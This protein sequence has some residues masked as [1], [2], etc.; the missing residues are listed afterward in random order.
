MKQIL[1]FLLCASLLFSVLAVNGGAAEENSNRDAAVAEVTEGITALSTI[2]RESRSDLQQV[3]QKINEFCYNHGYYNNDLIENLADF[4]IAIEKFNDLLN[5]REGDTNNDKDVNAKDAL[6]VLKYSVGK[7]FFDQKQ[8]F[9]AD[10]DYNNE[11]NAKDA[12][13]MLQYAVGKRTEFPSQ[14]VDHTPYEKVDYSL[15]TAKGEALYKAT[16][17]SMFDRTRADGFTQTSLTG[18]YEGMYLRD[19][20]IQVMAH[21][22]N[23]DYDNAR[24]ILNYITDYHRSKNLSYVMHIIRTYNSYFKQADTTFFFLHAWYQ[25][26]TQAPKTEDNVAYIETSCEMV[27]RFANYYL[28]NGYLHDKYDLIFNESFEHSRDGSYWQSYDLLTNVYASQALYEM[29]NYFETLSPGNAQKW[30]DASAKI[31]AGIHKNLT[32]EFDGSLMYAELRGRSEKNIKADPNTPEEFIAGFSWVNLAPMSCDWY[33]V[34]PE[35]LEHTYQTYL[36]YGS[37]RYTNKQNKKRYKMLEVYS[38]FNVNR[39]RRLNGGDHIIGKGLAWEI[40]YCNKMGYTDRL[41]QIV[42]FMEESSTTFYPEVWAYGGGVNDTGNQEQA[43]WLLI[44]ICALQS[45]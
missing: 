36:E 42:A 41:A 45:K 37:V 4:D 21:I 40:M 7:G 13:M 10:V 34:K 6:D 14:V 3:N 28:D 20:T 44:A 12:L 31:A 9:A 15:N 33:A 8:M 17:Q 16:Y 18:A 19:A 11:Y 23:G 39:P 25:F 5:Y 26:A 1:A 35:I 32:V 2:T 27:K 30:K 38:T 24:L 29:G 22:A 43:C